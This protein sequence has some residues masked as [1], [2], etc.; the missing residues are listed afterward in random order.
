MTGWSCTSAVLPDS[1]GSLSNLY[2]L[3][4]ESTDIVSLLESFDQLKNLKHVFLP[5]MTLLDRSIEMFRGDSAKMHF[6]KF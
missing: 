5:D 4:L 1:F 6:S 2:R 3:Y